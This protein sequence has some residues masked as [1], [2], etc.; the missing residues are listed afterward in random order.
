MRKNL[1]FPIFYGI[2]MTSFTVYVVLDTFVITRVYGAVE[3]TASAYTASVDESETTGSVTIETETTG[4]AAAESSSSVKRSKKKS[5][6]S[7]TAERASAETAETTAETAVSTENTYQD[8]NISVTLTE[9]TVND[10]AVYVADVTLS[11]AEYLK[12]ALAQGLYG[13]NVTESTSDMAE[14]NNAIL[15]INGDYY[16]AQE[17]G[18]VLR[19]GVLYRSTAAKNQ[20]DLVIYADG[21]FQIINESEVTAE[22]LLADG[23]VQILSFGPALVT[24]GEI[25][26]TASEE[27]GQ[28]K[29][30]NPRTAIGV[31][32]DL[33][34]IFV[35]S[36]GRTD[37]SEG[38]SLYE[39]ASFME[40][41]GAETAYNLDGGGSST[42]V[43]NGTLINNPTST[44]NSIKE[45]S[46]S[47]IVY[48]GY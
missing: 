22:E 24:D 34:Y 1:L 10:T 39:L 48:I 40:S 15:A 42:M 23:A 38:L 18:Y 46:V 41:L 13:K 43:F 37:E 21:S 20:E 29:S 2:L 17:K 19:N 47:D 16:G 9:Y 6:S 45:R 14:D 4:T 27:V 28:A 7:G 35:V 30:S 12:T 33:H 5:S 11:S 26:V 44:G 31:I 8:E 3:S 36:D 32:D 25:A